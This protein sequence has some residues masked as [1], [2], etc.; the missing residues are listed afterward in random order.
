MLYIYFCVS[1]MYNQKSCQVNRYTLLLITNNKL[2]N[3]IA[4]DVLKFYTK[5]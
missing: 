1:S 3:P 5:N 2:F 4:A